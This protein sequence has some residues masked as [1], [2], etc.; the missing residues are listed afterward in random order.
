MA[1][2]LEEYQSLTG[3]TSDFY[4]HISKYTVDV[5]NK[6]VTVYTS[7]HKDKNARDQGLQPV[8]VKKQQLIGAS[9]GEIHSKGGDEPTT[10]TSIIYEQLYDVHTFWKNSNAIPIYEVMNVDI[11]AHDLSIGKEISRETAINFDLIEGTDYLV[12]NDLGE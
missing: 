12:V 3:Y 1:W 11:I 8:E 10:T 5:I 7:I 9:F 4:A 6:R 2:K